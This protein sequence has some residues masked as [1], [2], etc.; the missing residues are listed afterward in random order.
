MFGG[1]V[2]AAVG[3]G[4]LRRWRMTTLTLIRPVGLH[5]TGPGME[6]IRWSSLVLIAGWALLWLG[7]LVL[8]EPSGPVPAATA[9][10]QRAHD[11]WPLRAGSSGAAGGPRHC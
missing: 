11:G 8:V 9:K 1:M 10:H 5:G 2:G 7:N 6:G 3:T 4:A